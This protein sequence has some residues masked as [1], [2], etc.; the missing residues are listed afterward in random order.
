MNLTYCLNFLLKLLFERDWSIQLY[1]VYV[2]N[3]I[4]MFKNYIGPKKNI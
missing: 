2:L 3:Q 4:Q 1:L